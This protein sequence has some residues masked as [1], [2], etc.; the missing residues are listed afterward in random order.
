MKRN[1]ARFDM[2]QRYETLH[3]RAIYEQLNDQFILFTSV[4]YSIPTHFFLEAKF[5]IIVLLQFQLKSA[6]T[7][8]MN[9]VTI[10]N[11]TVESYV[12]ILLRD[13]KKIAKGPQ[14]CWNRN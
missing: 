3:Y 6:R 9:C 1:E 12:T 14:C 8:G 5:V 2:K 13:I 11:V 10:T 4:N 7:L